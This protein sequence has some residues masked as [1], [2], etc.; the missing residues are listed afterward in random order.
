VAAAA[1]GSVCSARLQA[2][3]QMPLHKKQHSKINA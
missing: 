2:Q 1:Q 3:R